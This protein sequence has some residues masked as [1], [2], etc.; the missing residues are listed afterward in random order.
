R[1]SGDEN[2]KQLAANTDRNTK[3]IKQSLDEHL[4]GVSRFTSEFARVLPIIS[5]EL[6][7]LKDHNSLAK[8]TNIKRFKWQNKAALLARKA[9]DESREHGF[10]GVNMASTGCGKTI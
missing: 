9:Q 3:Q 10:F 5:Q 7:T 2:Y 1:V 8:D 4:L 6:P